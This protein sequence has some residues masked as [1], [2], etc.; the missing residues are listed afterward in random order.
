MKIWDRVC[1]LLLPGMCVDTDKTKT[2]MKYAR[3]RGTRFSEDFRVHDVG[4]P[5]VHLITRQ[6][7]LDILAAW[8]MGECT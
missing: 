7:Y 4:R 8:S 3:Q 1:S 2:R 6:K 5:K